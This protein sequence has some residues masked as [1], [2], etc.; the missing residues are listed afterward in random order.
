MRENDN[1]SEDLS[2][3][4]G[5]PMTAQELAQGLAGGGDVEKVEK[6]HGNGSG[7]NFLRRVSRIFVPNKNNDA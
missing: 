6:E 4:M 1:R 2:V 7:L 5:T 3:N